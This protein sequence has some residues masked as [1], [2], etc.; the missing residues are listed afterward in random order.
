MSMFS[1]FKNLEKIKRHLKNS[2][3]IKM[4]MFGSMS[5]VHLITNVAYILNKHTYK[6]LDFKCYIT[7]D[8]QVCFANVFLYVK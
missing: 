8:S 4:H 2:L 5:G 3:L 1:I 7:S 6:T